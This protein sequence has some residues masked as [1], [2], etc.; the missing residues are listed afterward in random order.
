[1]TK[2]LLGLVAGAIPLL[3]QTQQ[4][5]TF[6]ATT[7]LVLIDA[8]VVDKQGRHVRELKASA[9]TLLDRGKPQTIATFEEVLH[10]RVPVAEAARQATVSPA[11]VDVATNQSGANDRL[12]VM[13]V[14]D[15][16]LYKE[17]TDRA[18]TIARDVVARLGAGASMAVLFTS[19]DRSTEV[20]QNRRTLTDAI[21]QLTGRKPYPRPSF[22]LEP[23]NVDEFGGI[24]NFYDNLQ[25]IRT[26]RDAAS[27]LKAGKTSRKAFVLVSEW[28]PQDLSGLFQAGAPP[29][30]VEGGEDYVAGRIEESMKV[31]RDFATLDYELVDMMDR[32]RRSNVV[33]Y[34]IDPRGFVSNQQLMRECHPMLPLRKD[35]C[36]PDG[37]IPD[38]FAWVRQAQHGLE[39]SAE[40]SGGF[41]ITNTD[42]FTGGIERILEDLDHYYLLGF[43]PAD[44]DK[45]GYR[46]VD[47]KVNRPDVTLRFRRG[48]EAGPPRETEK[49]GEDP[50]LALTSA[51]VPKS[52][53]PLRIA[54]M[55]MTNPPVERTSNTPA[56]AT[57]RVAVALEVS[58]PVERVIRADGFVA[59]KIRYTV[60][61]A[62]LRDGKAV[63]QFTNNADISSTKAVAVR[64][65]AVVSYQLPVE[66]ALRPGRYQIRA[67]VISERM[68][69]SGS[70]YTTLEVPNVRPA[71]LV[72]S[73]LVLGYMTD[74]RLPVTTSGTRSSL[75]FVPTLTREFRAT[76]TLRLYFEVAPPAT[77][78]TA[79]TDVAR[80]TVEI[81]DA[82]G[83]VVRTWRPPPVPGARSLV[84][85]PVPLEGLA[86]GTYTLRAV[87]T[88][89]QR[90]TKEL[91]IVI[92]E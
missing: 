71:G 44:P 48:Y 90:V 12:I 56:A 46:N 11:Q 66:F 80:T 88:A 45:K 50:L 4:Q 79:R 61:A 49:K 15:I 21:D 18:R 53:L 65:N 43:Y 89:S 2:K 24:Q 83:R 23:R 32:M 37:K 10:E 35:P 55:P 29:G 81:L 62:N 16:H 54:A 27:L 77:A 92:R 82:A 42:D 73:A 3:A 19:G 38:W 6:K 25:T 74:T 13:V 8:V 31:S 30:K 20:T 33:V 91:G 72:M 76:E 60:V 69:E 41:A 86:P 17:R 39:I 7:D 75:P 22:G 26:L 47:V 64:S 52:A 34:A 70:V 58:T 14:D 78:T 63:A 28:I 57:T 40:A 84:D 5:P 67:A 36:L 59:D 68:Q 51:I 9:F 87:V 1:M 85:L